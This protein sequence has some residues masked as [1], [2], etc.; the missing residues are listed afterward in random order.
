[1]LSFY[2]SHLF[3][4]Q[5][6]FMTYLQLIKNHLHICTNLEETHNLYRKDEIN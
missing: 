5:Y 2:Y 6:S 4:P 3:N 1:M